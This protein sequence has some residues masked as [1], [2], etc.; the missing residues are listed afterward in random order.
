MTVVGHQPELFGRQLQYAVSCQSS[1]G[2][3]I[4]GTGLL[5]G[6]DAIQI[7]QLE[8]VTPK[9]RRISQIAED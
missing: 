9:E 5:A 7:R 6:R 3:Q 1:V 4:P 8:G 2:S